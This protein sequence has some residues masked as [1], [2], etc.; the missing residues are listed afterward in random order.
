[1]P[2]YAKPLDRI[3]VLVSPEQHPKVS[4]GQAH[5]VDLACKPGDPVYAIADGKIPHVYADTLD[6]GIVGGAYFGYDVAVAKGEKMPRFL[7]AHVAPVAGVARKP[8]RGD[9]IGHC[10]G[11]FLHLGCNS[12]AE[13]EKV[14][15]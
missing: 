14:I 5:A 2:D 1:M 10:T 15:G 3:S 6:G 7:Y 12:L 9:L 8:K 4:K 11:T 13:L